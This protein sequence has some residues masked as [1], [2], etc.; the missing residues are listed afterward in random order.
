MALASKGKLLAD[1]YRV[2]GRLGAGGMA[3]VVLADDER[4]GRKVAVKRLHAESPDEAALRF[5]REA[6][7]G[8]SLNHP[9]IV[10]VYD[11]VSDDEGVLIVMEYVDGRTLR[12]EMDSGPMPPARAIEV[13]SGVAAALDHAHEHGVVHRDVKPANVLIADRDGSVKLTDLGIAT[14]AERTHITRS[15]VVLGTAAYMAPERLDGEAGDAAVDVY[16]MAAVAFEM[17]SGRKAVTGRTAVEIARWVM[18][19]P[20]PDLAEVLPGA[21]RRAAEVLK[22]GLAKDPADRPASAGELVRELSA[23]YAEAAMER[24]PAARPRDPAAVVARVAK[25][26]ERRDP[27]VL[28]PRL[29]PGAPAQRRPWRAVAALAVV[30]AAVLAAVLLAASGG[31]GG[32]SST[33]AGRASTQPAVRKQPHARSAPKPAAPAA[34]SA[35]PAS[36]SQPTPPQAAPAGTPAQTLTDFYT[37][38]ANHDFQGAWALGTGNL[39]G[40]FGSID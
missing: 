9:N 5:E 18:E 11:I 13:L 24:P 8:A 17:L 32:G 33:T 36:G 6:K 15:G 1:R 34:P 7:L 29:D 23:A 27:P 21:P 25:T 2:A 20:P 31:G 14:A 30:A 3:V 38:A 39:H 28:P 37:R 40:Q 19:A 16:A 35:P 22:R 26:A 12:L 10:A 4:L